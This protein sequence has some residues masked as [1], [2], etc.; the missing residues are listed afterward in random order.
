MWQLQPHLQKDFS[1][2]DTGTGSESDL[3]QRDQ[4]SRLLYE[5]DQCRTR[6][7]QGLRHRGWRMSR[8][9]GVLQRNVA[10]GSR[11]SQ[12]GPGWEWFVRLR[13]D[14][15]TSAMDDE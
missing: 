4:D 7:V 10:R 13:A 12:S 5:Q 14:D 3:Q 6:Q 9:R 15:S 8:R 1:S 2:R 11:G